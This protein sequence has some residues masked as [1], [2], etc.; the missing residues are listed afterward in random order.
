MLLAQD[1]ASCL[2]VTSL[3]PSA[4]AIAAAGDFR[5]E[6]QSPDTLQAAGKGA[7][8]HV[9]DAC[10]APGNK[11]MHVAALL[12]AHR[13]ITGVNTDTCDQVTAFERSTARLATLRKRLDAGGENDRLCRFC[14][15]YIA[16][17]RYI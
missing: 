5:S 14:R 7:S 3:L 11:T 16:L 12:H 15:L 6:F 8:V 1:K 4:A 9:I 2:P 13:T 17:S 10:A